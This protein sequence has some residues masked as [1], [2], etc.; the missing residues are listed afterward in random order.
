MPRYL[1][2][3]TIGTNFTN[4][5][6]LIITSIRL[7]TMVDAPSMFKNPPSLEKLSRDLD[8][9]LHTAGFSLVMDGDSPKPQPKL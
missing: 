1:P 7:S 6:K 9:A 4:P 5:T 8:M 3:Q 2:E